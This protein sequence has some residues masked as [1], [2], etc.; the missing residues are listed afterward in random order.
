MRRRGLILVA[1]L[2]IPASALCDNQTTL[3]AGTP[4]G[5]FRTYD[6]AT[7][8]RTTTIEVRNVGDNEAVGVDVA[9]ELPGGQQHRLSGP[10]KIAPNKTAKYSDDVGEYITGSQKLKAVVTCSN[11]R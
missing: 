6:G 5:L 1:L 3:R 7:R 4:N 8:L 2:L 11:C 9:V 10:K